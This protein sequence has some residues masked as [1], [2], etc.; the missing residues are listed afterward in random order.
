MFDSRLRLANQIYDEVK[1]IF[2]N[3]YS[4]QLYSVTSN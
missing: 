4:R 1:R 2:K 3:W